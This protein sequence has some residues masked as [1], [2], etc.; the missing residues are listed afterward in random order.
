LSVKLR[1][2]RMGSTNRPFF[3]VVAIDS[4]MRR[5]G[6]SIEELGYYD[7]LKRP[8][9]VQLKEEAIFQWLGRGAEP[10]ATVR[11]LLRDKGM[12]LKWELLQNGVSA[13][14]ATRRVVAVL[15]KQKPKTKRPRPSKKAQAKAAGSAAGAAA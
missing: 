5:D 7:P 8:A 1:L 2:R 10:S 15:E 6:R 14:E 9:V 11:E 12:L 3:R 4:R 13:E